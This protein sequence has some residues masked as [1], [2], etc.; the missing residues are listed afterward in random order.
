MTTKQ[1]DKAQALIDLWNQRPPERRTRLDVFPF[2]LEV[3]ESRPH[4]LWGWPG[5]DDYQVLASI[6]QPYIHEPR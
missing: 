3:Q 5:P 2:R 4:L 1:Q 6:L